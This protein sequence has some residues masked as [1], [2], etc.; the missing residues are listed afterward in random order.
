MKRNR[1]PKGCINPDCFHCPLKD[2][3]K[4]GSVDESVEI[5]AVLKNVLHPKKEGEYNDKLL[6][7][8]LEKW[9]NIGL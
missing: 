1:T 2:C 3:T 9:E 4:D 8:S 6:V 7:V 5:N